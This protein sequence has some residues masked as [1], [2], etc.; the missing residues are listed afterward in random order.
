MLTF[1]YALYEA[2]PMETLEGNGSSVLPVLG[3]EDEIV[4]AHRACRVTILEATTGAGKTTEVPRKSSCESYFVCMFSV[5][6]RCLS[7]MSFCTLW[8]VSS[9]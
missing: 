4:S 3:R 1:L 6:T 2:T 8:S 5:I 7:F 9:E